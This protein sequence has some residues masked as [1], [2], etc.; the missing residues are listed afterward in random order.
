MKGL[1][2]AA[3][4]LTLTGFQAVNAASDTAN[5]TATV[6]AAIAIANVDDLEFGAAVQGDALKVVATGDTEAAEFTVTGQAS[7]AYTITL[8]ATATMITAGGGSADTEIVVSSFTSLPA[9]GANGMLDAGGSQTLLVGGQRAALSATQT[10]G[11]YT[12]TFT[13]DVVY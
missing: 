5:A 8:P 7:T 12:T 13:V 11:A 1:F 3:T 4:F 2:L 10:A 6:T 9:A